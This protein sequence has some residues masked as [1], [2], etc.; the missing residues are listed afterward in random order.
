[1]QCCF[2]P[3]YIVFKFLFKNVAI[4]TRKNLRRGSIVFSLTVAYSKRGSNYFLTSSFP[5]KV[6]PVSLR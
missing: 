1:M 4:F 6:G 3:L 2:F 5:L